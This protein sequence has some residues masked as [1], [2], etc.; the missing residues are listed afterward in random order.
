[1]IKKRSIVI[2]TF[3]QNPGGSVIQVLYILFPLKT[4]GP[5]FLRVQNWGHQKSGEGLATL[6]QVGVKMKLRNSLHQRDW[7]SLSGTV[8]DAIVLGTISSCVSEPIP[9]KPKGKPGRPRKTKQTSKKINEAGISGT[10]IP[11][12]N[13]FHPELDSLFLY[14]SMQID[15]KQLIV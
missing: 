13:W 9:K 12:V 8:P 3:L 5:N 1:M 7:W 2:T 14:C 4:S 6:K 15:Y 11:Q 10:A